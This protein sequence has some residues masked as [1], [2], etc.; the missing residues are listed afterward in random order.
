MSI[1]HESTGE[2]ILRVFSSIPYVQPFSRSYPIL[3]KWRDDGKD[4]QSMMNRRG[5]HIRRNVGWKSSFCVCVC[6]QVSMHTS[7]F[8]RFNIQFDRCVCVCL[9]KPPIIKHSTIWNKQW[10]NRPNRHNRQHCR[11]HLGIFPFGKLANTSS[12]TY[13]QCTPNDP[14]RM[15]REREK[16]KCLNGNAK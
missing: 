11:T 12:S 7:T 9:W 14:I 13:I 2:M 16:K 3:I 4:I 10:N 6:I 1:S 8:G 5:L 15:M